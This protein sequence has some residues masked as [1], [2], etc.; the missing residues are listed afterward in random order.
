MR[1]WWIGPWCYLASLFLPAVSADDGF[2]AVVPEGEKTTP[3]RKVTEEELEGERKEQPRIVLSEERS[4]E[5]E[6]KPHHF[7]NIPLSPLAKMFLFD[8]LSFPEEQEKWRYDFS[9]RPN[10]WDRLRDRSELSKYDGKPNTPNEKEMFQVFDYLLTDGLWKDSNSRLANFMYEFNEMASEIRDGVYDATHKERSLLR[11]KMR[12]RAKGSLIKR[13]F[14]NSKIGFSAE[15]TPHKQKAEVY[16][17]CWWG[18][19]D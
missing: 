1:G 12:E 15:A 17:R 8:S 10:K 3:V 2:V 7:S 4:A 6:K 13:L 11:E 14:R 5:E 18:G 19:E 16:W 9:G